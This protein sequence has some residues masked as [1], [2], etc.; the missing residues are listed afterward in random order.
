MQP[1]AAWNQEPETAEAVLRLRLFDLVEPIPGGNLRYAGVFDSAQQFVECRIDPVQKA[2]GD[3]SGRGDKQSRYL[4]LFRHS[5]YRIVD[6]ENAC[7][8]RMANAGNFC[9]RTSR[10]AQVRYDRR[11]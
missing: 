7:S 4:C 6:F 9:S 2:C 1:F 8:R 11:N 10:I 3:V 5:A